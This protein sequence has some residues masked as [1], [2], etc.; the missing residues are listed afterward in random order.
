MT[1]SNGCRQT[2]EQYAVK[3]F[4]VCLNRLAWLG[5]AVRDGKRGGHKIFT[6]PNLYNFY[7]SSYN[8]GHGRNPEIKP[9]YITNILN[10]LDTYDTE[11][12]EFLGKT[13]DDEN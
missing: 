12:R 11:L 13:D 10:I 8:C 6:H 9:A 5:F 7:S 1:S 3:M 4:V 2:N